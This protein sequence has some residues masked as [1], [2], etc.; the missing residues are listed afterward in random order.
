LSSNVIRLIEKEKAES[1]IVDRG[2]NVYSLLCAFCGNLIAYQGNFQI[3]KNLIE[4]GFQKACEV[5]EPRALGNVELQYGFFFIAM[6][7]WKLAVEHLKNAIKYLEEV[8]AVV[9]LSI[10]LSA[11]GYAFYFL[12]DFE[13]SCN[14]IEKGMRAN[15]DSGSKFF[16]SWHYCLSG[17]VH[18]AKGDQKKALG[19]VENALAL[20]QRFDEKW[21]EGFSSIWLGRIL[22]KTDASQKEK[23]EDSI[24]KGIQI[25]E[26]IQIKP[27]Y[28]QGYLALGEI[29][30]ESGQ[31]EKALKNLKRAEGLFKEMEI[32]YWLAR[33]REV[34]EKL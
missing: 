5:N 32:D 24:L 2:V 20:S 17:A 15:I 12:G 26:K 28:S 27:Y 16:I 9:P 11:L 25:L 6:G 30:A 21:M 34:I 31:A 13:S 10:T 14:Y 33:T 7:D 3:G 22:A 8:K 19:F 29:H 1:E 23:A 18:F 4:K